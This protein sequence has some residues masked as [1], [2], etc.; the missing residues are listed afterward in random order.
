VKGEGTLKE[1]RFGK[2][3]MK[4][5]FCGVCGTGVMGVRDS[6][7]V[8]VN[9]SL[10]LLR[11]EVEIGADGIG[12]ANMLDLPFDIYGLKASTYD[13]AA[14]EPKYIPPPFKGEE[15]SAEME[16][17]KIY[18]GSCHC[19]AV[20]LAMIVGGSLVDGKQD[21]VECNCS[22]CV[23]VRLLFIPSSSLSKLLLILTNP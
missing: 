9:V 13:G 16:S 19:G 20:G 3:S 6:G 15:P 10:L 18:Y 12:Q 22:S 17:A 8:G 4:H 14:L 23:R 7:G 11:F 21:V 1:Y 2:E 5:C